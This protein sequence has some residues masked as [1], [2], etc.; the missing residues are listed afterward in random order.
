M[1]DLPHVAVVDDNKLQRLILTRL[2]E[3]EYRI[4]AFASGDELL[5][6]PHAFDA[7]LL[8]IEMPGRNG[9]EVCR[10]LRAKPESA[11]T[12]IIFVSSHDTAPERVAAYEAG[13]D[14]FVTKP[15]A[16]DELRY[17]LTGII[18]H[19]HQLHM[20]ADQSSAAQQ[21]AFTAMSSMGDLG[22]VIEFLRTS[23]LA[24]DYPA[25]ADQ[26][27]KAMQAWNL[28]GAVQIRGHGGSLERTSDGTMSPLQSSVLETLRDIGRIFEMGSRAIINY[29]HVSLLVENLPTHDPDKVGRLRDDLAV[30]AE[31]ADM[32]IAGLDAMNERDQQKFGIVDALAELRLALARVSEQ[33]RSNRLVGQNMV[34]ESMEQIAHTLGTLGL[35]ENQQNYVDDLIKETQDESRQ[36]FDEAANLDTEFS[37]LLRRLEKL[38]RP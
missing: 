7:I 26:L 24:R 2:L 13:G 23:T 10:L 4:N 8:D 11:Q 31:S 28:R 32:R 33:T 18:E 37:E 16:V 20:L 3:S 34:L 27:L 15:I 14:D 35:T 29:Q 6:N 9:Y 17:K 38:A 21:V 22:V 1:S 30:L 19:R 5:A 12:P 36:Y 25:I